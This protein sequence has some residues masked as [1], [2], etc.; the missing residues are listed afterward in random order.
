MQRPETLPFATPSSIA[1]ARVTMNG[2]MLVPTAGT[3]IQPVT[4][5]STLTCN[6]P[7]G[8]SAVPFTKIIGGKLWRVGHS[9]PT[10]VP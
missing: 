2:S 8:P 4:A 5:S 9:P 7:H 3:F 10:V 1:P 6:L